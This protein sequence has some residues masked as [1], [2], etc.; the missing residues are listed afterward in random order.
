MLKHLILSV[1]YTDDWE[2][3]MTQLP[4]LL[5]QFGTRQLTLVYVIETHKRQHM[6]DNEGSVAG[7]L[8]AMAEE[9]ASRLGVEATYQVG[10]G[11]VASKILEIAR[12]KKADGVVV[13]NTSHSEGRELFMGNNAMNLARM[14]QLPLLVL[15]VDG[16]P[17]TDYAPVIL[18]T[19]GSDSARAA[20]D[21]FTALMEAGGEG[22]VL[23]VRPDIDSDQ[24]DAVD[25]HV[26]ELANR[27]SRVHAEIRQGHPVD[28]ILSI[29]RDNKP[30]VTI[31]GKRGNTPI[32]EVML[33]S[34]S[35][36]VARGSTS[37]VL[38]IP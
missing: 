2:R 33:G 18:A 32:P 26:H 28:A 36:E 12:L 16:T 17:A 14:T 25:Q 34:V 1:D 6:E 30:A 15:P 31:M 22:L 24:V 11:F 10:R 29:I 21:C 9:L 19:D 5:K 35:K 23:W 37:P 7:K 27:F 8:K 3:A 4:M 13:C 20:Q 38:L